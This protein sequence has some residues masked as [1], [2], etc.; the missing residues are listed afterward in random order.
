MIVFRCDANPHLGLGHLMRCR[1]LARALGEA[2]LACSMVGP[3]EIYR[4]DQDGSLFQHWLPV[5]GWEGARPD[6]AAFVAIANRLGARIAVMDDYRIDLDYQA[7]LDKAS[8][9]W[10][11]FEARGEL[12]LLADLVLNANPAV[13][14]DAYTG[15]LKPGTRLL[16]GPRYAILRPE[17]SGLAPRTVKPEVE[18]VLLTFGGGDDRGS[19]VQVLEAVLPIA[20]LQTRFTLISGGHN[21]AN[22]EIS[23]WIERHASGCARL[24]IGPPNMVE[25]M[26]DADL[27]I[28]AGGTTTY[29]AACCG[30]PMVLISI[31]DN[32][33]KQAQAWEREGIARYAGPRET[34][35]DETLRD[36]FRTMAAFEVRQRVADLTRD[37]KFDGRGA[38]RVAAAIKDLRVAD[39][40]SLEGM[41]S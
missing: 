40:K 12:P 22:D 20:S 30:L 25:L 18:N 41:A 3:S 29:E 9:R 27:A 2:G 13:S 21:P 37:E 34:C 39:R 14:P 23:Q 6:A 28:M 16:L 36:A 38:A 31:A 5:S 17:F 4:T 19:F 35:S 26:L 33:V 24:V 7:I 11:Q 1:S 8:I 10:L 32:Q 15:L